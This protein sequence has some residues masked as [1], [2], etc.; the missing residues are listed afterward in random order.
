MLSLLLTCWMTTQRRTRRQRVQHIVSSM[1]PPLSLDFIRPRSLRV[2]MV[3]L[4]TFV[5]MTITWMKE[6]SAPGPVFWAGTMYL[7]QCNNHH[8]CQPRPYWLTACP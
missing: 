3:P 4:E 8:G 1:A 7:K 6:F 5:V 2:S